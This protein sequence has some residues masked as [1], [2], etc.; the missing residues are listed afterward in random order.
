VFPKNSEPLLQNFLT[1]LPDR[2]QHPEPPP[3]LSW[4]RRLG[5]SPR[6]STRLSSSPVWESRS[7]PERIRFCSKVRHSAVAEIIDYGCY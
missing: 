1:L 5:K 4:L 7:R 3:D 2:L 6:T